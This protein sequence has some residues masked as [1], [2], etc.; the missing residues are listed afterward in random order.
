MEG[1]KAEFGHTVLLRLY[2][3]P[4]TIIGS[5]FFFGETLSWKSHRRHGLGDIR[6]CGFG[7]S[8]TSIVLCV[9]FQR[10]KF[11]FSGLFVSQSDF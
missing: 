11:E 5:T 2:R 8:Q 9:Y 4:K 1:G 10:L 7:A 6:G 3:K